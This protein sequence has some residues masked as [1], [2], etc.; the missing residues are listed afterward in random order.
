MPEITELVDVEALLVAHLSSDA[1]VTAIADDRVSTEL[2]AGFEPE[3]RIQ[4]FRVGGAPTEAVTHHIDRAV[5]QLNIYGS[6][7]AEA[8]DTA[9]AALSGLLRARS[10]A[11][12]LGS[13]T[14]IERLTGPTWSPDPATDAPRYLL[15]VA[16]TVH[17]LAVA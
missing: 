2:P 11:H 6:T 17:P 5:V 13:V 10:A 16:I 4:L 7:K 14:H 12:P 1:G 3:A 9:R 15:T 8:F